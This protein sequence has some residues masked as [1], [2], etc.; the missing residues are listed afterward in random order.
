MSQGLGRYGASGCPLPVE[1]WTTLPLPGHMSGNT[2]SIPAN[3]GAHLSFCVQN[4]WIIDHVVELS[5]QPPLPRFSWYS[6]AQRAHWES[7]HQHKLWCGIW[8][9][10]NNKDTLALRKFQVYRSYLQSIWAKARPVFGRQIPFYVIFSFFFIF[11]HVYF[12]FLIHCTGFQRI[13]KQ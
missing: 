1:P 6:L 7:S 4:F 8:L 3:Q 10:M 11:I 12:F 13:L 9:I 5:P 2:K